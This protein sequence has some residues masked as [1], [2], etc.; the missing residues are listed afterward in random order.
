MVGHHKTKGTITIFLSI[1][2]SAVFLVIGTFTDG[3][4]LRLAHSHVQRSNKSALS[5]VLANYKN[6]LK[7]EYGLFGV[8]IDEDSLEETFE[9]YFSKNLGIVGEGNS[10]Y[11]FI[12]DD[13][14]LDSTYSLEDKDVFEKQILEFMKYRAPYKLATELIEKV[15]GIDNISKGSKIYTQ[16]IKTDKQAAEIG[17]IQLL[18]ESK[19]KRINELNLPNQLS[20]YKNDLESQNT[21][22][23]EKNKKFT[24]STKLLLMLKQIKSKN[25]I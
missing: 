2:L 8:Y 13:I 24:K 10:M 4:R 15:K 1:V 21:L 25:K 18:L 14:N 16:K 19:T 7:D 6:E 11:D 3:A 5:S 17:E 9:E 20:I 23:N 12:I 22:L